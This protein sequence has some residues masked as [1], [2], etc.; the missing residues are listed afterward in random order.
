MYLC[1]AG[2]LRSLLR[3]LRLYCS[4]ACIVVQE[5]ERER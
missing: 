4:G 1:T 5:R 3:S 2:L